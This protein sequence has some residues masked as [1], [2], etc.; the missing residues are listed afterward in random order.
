MPASHVP[1]PFDWRE[2]SFSHGLPTRLNT[3]IRSYCDPMALAPPR[4]KLA[5][6]RLSVTQQE[7]LSVSYAES[8]IGIF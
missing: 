6:A 1:T 4:Y 7:I 8:E 2:P 3:R 5:P